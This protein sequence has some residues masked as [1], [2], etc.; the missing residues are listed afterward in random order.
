MFSRWFF[1]GNCFRK[2]TTQ[3]NALM[4][5]RVLLSLCI[6]TREKS[7]LYLKQRTVFSK[8]LASFGDFCISLGCYS[9]ILTVSF[10]LFS[11]FFLFLLHPSILPP[12]PF[13]LVSLLLLSSWFSC[14]LFI[15]P[16]LFFSFL[17]HPSILPPLCSTFLSSNYSSLPPFLSSHIIPPFGISSD[18][19]SSCPFIFFPLFS[20]SL[21]LFSRLYPIS[22]LLTPLLSLS[23][24]DL[25]YPM[26][27]FLSLLFLSRH[28]LRQ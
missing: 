20:T 10:Q 14:L 21:S 9:F 5:V 1:C 15:F 26:Y 17:L 24:T 11:T 3:N 19:F 23:S 18:L 4:H 27:P 16:P 25:F 6:C 2:H 8:E 13:L 22:T 12:S 7:T 28:T